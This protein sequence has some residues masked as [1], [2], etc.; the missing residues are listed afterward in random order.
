MAENPV[1]SDLFNRADE[2]PL[3]SP[4][5]TQIGYGSKVVSNQAVNAW[6]GNAGSLYNSGT[7]ANDQ[8]VKFTSVSGTYA[9]LLIRS[10]YVSSSNKSGYLVWFPGAAGSG[11]QAYRYSGAAPS[12]VS[13]GNFTTSQ[14]PHG[15]TVKLTMVGTALK[16]FI[17]TTQECSYTDATYSGGRCGI[18]PYA[19]TCDNFIAGDITADSAFKAAWAMRTNR[20]IGGNA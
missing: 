17:G 9:G 6:T 20:V 12:F 5:V 16:G 3:G 19:A 18:A 1:V 15:N 10:T 4:W 11:G 14:A 7:L 8:Y 2:N 13:L